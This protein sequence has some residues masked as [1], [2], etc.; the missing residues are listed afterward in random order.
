MGSFPRPDI[1][2]GIFF[3]YLRLDNPMS[4]DFL[5][6]VVDGFPFLLAPLSQVKG[7]ATPKSMH[8]AKTPNHVAPIGNPVL[9]IIGGVGGVISSQ[10]ASFT[11]FIQSGAQE[12]AGSA[13]EK[14]RFVGSTARNLGEEVERRRDLI[15]KHISIFTSQTMSSFYPSNQKSISNAC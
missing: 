6:R 12:F 11:D 9:R 3:E 1:A 13:M 14:A 10:A 4:F 2:E 8:Q 15:G 5:D 7:V